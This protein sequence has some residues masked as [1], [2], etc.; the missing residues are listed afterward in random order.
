LVTDLETKQN[1]LEQTGLFR[2]AIQELEQ[3]SQA[4]ADVI[5]MKDKALRISV[6][7]LS[8]SSKQ[9]DM[10]IEAAKPKLKDRLTWAGVGAVGAILLKII[11]SGALL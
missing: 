11:I 1:L 8:L 10:K 7:Q 4:Q 5:L 9:C 2:E 6:E 3:K